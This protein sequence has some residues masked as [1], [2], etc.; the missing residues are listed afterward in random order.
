MHLLHPVIL[1]VQV[2][3][4]G[5]RKIYVICVIS[6]QKSYLSR[7][8]EIQQALKMSDFFKQHEVIHV[9]T[10]SRAWQPKA[11]IKYWNV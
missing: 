7:L 4:N 1:Q 6:T 8:R 5:F 11:A 2:P 10:A 9:T 3:M